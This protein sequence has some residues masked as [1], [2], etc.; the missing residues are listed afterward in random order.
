MLLLEPLLVGPGPG[1]VGSPAITERI[2]GRRT[3]LALTA[4]VAAAIVKSLPVRFETLDV[5]VLVSASRTVDL[6]MARTSER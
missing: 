6:S 3:R 1:H 2:R 5:N 4:L